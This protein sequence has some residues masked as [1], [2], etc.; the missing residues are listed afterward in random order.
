MKIHFI[1]TCYPH[2]SKYSGYNRL[3]DYLPSEFQISE[4]AATIYN[5]DAADSYSKQ[6][7]KKYGSSWPPGYGPYD[8]QAEIIAYKRWFF[9]GLDVVH[10]LDGE[11]GPLFLPKW[12]H[13]VP[14]KK[15]AKII[16]S[17]HQP[18]QILKKYI[19]PS[20]RGYVDCHI[21]LCQEQK[22]NGNHR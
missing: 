21:V 2:W 22:H 20:L 6:L 7:Q 13:K 19:R 18:H 15:P 4:Y 5:E 10:Y 17:Y 16:V 3:I 9:S 8:F 14:S 11:H 12:M 1:R